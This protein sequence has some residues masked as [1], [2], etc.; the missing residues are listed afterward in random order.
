MAISVE[1]ISHLTREDDM[2][3]AKEDEDMVALK[4]Q[5]C[6]YVPHPQDKDSE[7]CS[8]EKDCP[9]SSSKGKHKLTLMW[10]HCSGGKGECGDRKRR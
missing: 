2:H 3:T 6:K 4:N 5:L 10:D 1:T 8:L 7:M 9:A